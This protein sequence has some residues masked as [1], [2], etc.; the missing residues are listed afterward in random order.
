MVEYLTPEEAGRFLKVIHEWPDLDV[1]HMV[2]LAY[3]TG[4]RLGRSPSALSVK[5]TIIQ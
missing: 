1:R 2:L 4:M 5:T 3:V